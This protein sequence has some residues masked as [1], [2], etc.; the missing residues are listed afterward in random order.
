[1]ISFYKP[2]GNTSEGLNRLSGLK[3]ERMMIMNLYDLF[4]IY[5]E[6]LLMKSECNLLSAIDSN[7]NL[8]FSYLT[9]E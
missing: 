5:S 7:S 6:F 9:P 3:L 2:K 4:A 8:F 1:M